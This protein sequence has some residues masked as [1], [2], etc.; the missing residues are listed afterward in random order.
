MINESGAIATTLLAA[1]ALAFFILGLV[2]GLYLGAAILQILVGI[3]VQP[4]NTGFEA[5]FRVFA[6]AYA[7]AMLLNW[8]PVI[9]LLVPAYGVYLIFVGVRELHATTNARAAAVAL[10][11]FVLWLLLHL[12]DVLPSAGG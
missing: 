5:T 12:P 9:R 11:A 1:I 2:L 3:I 7:A 8:V 6:Y 10:S 4:T